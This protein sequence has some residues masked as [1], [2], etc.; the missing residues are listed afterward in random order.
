MRCGLATAVAFGVP[1]R[2]LAGRQTG[3]RNGRSWAGD[4]QCAQGPNHAKLES[5]RP[6]DS[7]FRSAQIERQI[8]CPVAV[9]AA[10][11]TRTAV[12]PS[13]TVS[14]HRTVRSIR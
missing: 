7:E 13:L 2:P 3:D 12:S 8:K 10:A 1:E 5:I 11:R 14:L 6:H 9:F 4:D